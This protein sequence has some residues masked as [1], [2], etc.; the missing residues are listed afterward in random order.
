MVEFKTHGSVPYQIIVLH[1]GPGAWGEMAPVADQIAD[2]C[3]VIEPYFL[4]ETLQGQLNEL[5]QIIQLLHLKTVSLLGFSWGA[6]LGYLFAAKYPALVTKLI[7]V[8]SGPYEHQYF[9]KLLETRESRM[10]PSQKELYLEI[11]QKLRD[12]DESNKNSLISQ[13]G[14]LCSKIDQYHPDPF[15]KSFPSPHFD[16]DRSTYFQQALNE[17]IGMRKSG[18]LLQ[19]AE[20]I[21]CPVVAIHGDYDPH[22]ANGVKIPLEQKIENFKFFLLE[23]CG[24]KPWIEKFAR[25]NFFNILKSVLF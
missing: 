7:L 3:G 5:K 8:G 9:L 20:K 24:H 17:V 4:E 25:T 2:K 15:E 16:L 18:E 21:L 1:G 6:W 11:L 23:K 19:Q 22:P 10:N 14:A 12:P 13:L